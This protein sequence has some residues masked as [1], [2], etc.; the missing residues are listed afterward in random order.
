MGAKTLTYVTAYVASDLPS[1]LAIHASVLVP[2]GH[3]VVHPVSPSIFKP[4]I[5]LCRHSITLY[6]FQLHF[7]FIHYRSFVHACIHSLIHSLFVHSFVCLFFH[8]ILQ[9]FVGCMGNEQSCCTAMQLQCLSRT[10][11]VPT[12]HASNLLCCAVQNTSAAV[13]QEVTNPCAAAVAAAESRAKKAVSTG[14]KV[15]CWPCLCSALSVGFGHTTKLSSPAS[16]CNM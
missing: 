10:G 12:L 9:S 3:S 6:F 14:S 8:P 4:L 11:V 2:S 15:Q 5:H 16:G 13:K 1:A 7:I